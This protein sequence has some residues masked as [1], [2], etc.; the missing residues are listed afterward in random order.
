M[1]SDSTQIESSCP[2]ESQT[3]DTVV[4]NIVS[5]WKLYNVFPLSDKWFPLLWMG[6]VDNHRWFQQTLCN[7][8]SPQLRI[9]RTLMGSQSQTSCNAIK[10]LLQDAQLQTH[11]QRE[12][13]LCHGC[14]FSS[15]QNCSYVFMNWRWCCNVAY[16]GLQKCSPVTATAETDICV[17]MET[18]VVGDCQ[19]R[20]VACH[21]QAAPL[22]LQPYSTLWPQSRWH[23]SE[24]WHPKL[25]HSRCTGNRSLGQRTHPHSSAAEELQVH[26]LAA[27]QWT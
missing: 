26:V 14:K 27:E 11:T 3:S 19:C 22:T 23:C 17:T 16:P 24:L 1:K 25:F 2:N 6:W 8:A 21:C 7:A 15:Y 4:V 18:D 10:V 9:C 5:S 20:V 13:L 12:Y